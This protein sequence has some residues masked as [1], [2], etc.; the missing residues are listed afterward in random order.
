[1][2]PRPEPRFSTRLRVRVRGV[3]SFGHPFQQD[4]YTRDISRRGA[5]LD[6]TPC[7]IDTA[8]VIEVQHR[9][10]RARFRVVWIGGYGTAL[11]A[12]AGLQCLEPEECILGRLPSPASPM[13]AMP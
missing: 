12:Q 4:A 11:H 5:R 8:A 1:M 13:T 6:G 3:D 7:V 9:G 10:R 2:A